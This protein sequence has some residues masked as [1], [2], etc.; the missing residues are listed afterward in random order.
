MEIQARTEVLRWS[1][2]LVLLAHLVAISWAWCPA[3]KT[4]ADPAL[5]AIRS[6]LRGAYIWTLGP[7]LLVTTCVQ[8]ADTR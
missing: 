1:L 4:P 7:I 2:G 8:R 6:F 5:G 3:A